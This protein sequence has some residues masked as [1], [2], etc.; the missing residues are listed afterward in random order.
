MV[1][2]L[3]AVKPYAERLEY[4]VKVID[5]RPYMDGVQ[6]DRYVWNKTEKSYY[7]NTKTEEI[8]EKD[9]NI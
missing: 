8:L 6:A 4:G 2:T 5:G 7:Y 9:K 1:A 3:C